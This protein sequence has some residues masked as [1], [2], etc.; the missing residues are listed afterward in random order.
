MMLWLPTRG[1]GALCSACAAQPMRPK[2]MIA[3]C[4]ATSMRW[5]SPVKCR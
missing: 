2:L 5:P 4:I 1:A 3:S